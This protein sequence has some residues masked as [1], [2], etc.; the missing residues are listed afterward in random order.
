MIFPSAR[1]LCSV[2]LLGLISTSPINVIANP[3]GAGTCDVSGISSSQHG[4]SVQSKGAT[5]YTITS[6]P[7]SPGNY[8]ITLSGSGSIKG[9]L[10]YAVSGTNQNT[11]I[12]QFS[13]LP[14]GIVAKQC[15]G[16]PTGSTVNHNSPDSKPLPMTFQWSSGGSM[17][18][19]AMI[20][21]V[22]VLEQTSG[23]WSNVQGF[24]FNLA[25]GTAVTGTSNTTI[26]NSG[27]QDSTA[28]T[29]SSNQFFLVAFINTY[30]L[31]NVVALIT[32][33]IYIFGAFAEYLLKRQQ[34]KARS[35]V[36]SVSGY[37]R[38]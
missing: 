16:G 20:K 38:Q 13:S 11:R 19:T 21:A 14:N 32:I 25:N 17:Q 30:P 34:I 29:D 10:L 31:F 7:T 5:P 1:T 12:G 33:F 28:T 35:Q 3:T 6:S 24:T 2:F 27:S 36:K 22:V 23:S 8:K 4:P 37:I 26:D 15:P 18:G 9:L